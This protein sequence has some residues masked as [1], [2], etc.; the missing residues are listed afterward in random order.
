MVF[1]ANVVCWSCDIPLT[2]GDVKECVAIDTRRV[3]RG[4]TEFVKLRRELTLV[5]SE[6]ASSE[7]G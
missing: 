6:C 3:V 5:C 7:K 2:D 4:G 1:R